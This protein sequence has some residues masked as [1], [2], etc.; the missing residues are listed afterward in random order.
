MPVKSFECAIARSQIGRY[1]AGDAVGGEA[2]RQLEAHI[3]G[4]SDCQRLIDSKKEDLLGPLAHAPT[5]EEALATRPDTAAIERELR[6]AAQMG[7]VVVDLPSVPSSPTVA[8]VPLPS[9]MPKPNLSGLGAVLARL[10]FPKL[11]REVPDEE[12]TVPMPAP[13]QN[14]AVQNAPVQNTKRPFGKAAVYG[15]ALLLVLGGMAYVGDPSSLLG[16]KA[17]APD[18]TVK[19]TAKSTTKPTLVP[20]ATGVRRSALGVPITDA[21]DPAPKA[22]PLAKAAPSRDANDPGPLEFDPTLNVAPAA[23]PAQKLAAKMPTKRA[24]PKAPAVKKAAPPVGIP[25]SVAPKAAAPAVAAAKPTLT[26]KAAP[27]AKPAQPTRK[28][29]PTVRRARRVRTAA[30]SHGVIRVYDETGK[31]IN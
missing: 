31:P 12:A 15:G 10:P 18:A 17:V 24:V 8:S 30:P 9:S 21:A 25:K 14:A 7:R 3:S 29:R 26:L 1:L 23:T 20:P 6:A 5:A 11:T 19:P 28:R 27:V 16:G 4:C 13:V 22:R 2:M